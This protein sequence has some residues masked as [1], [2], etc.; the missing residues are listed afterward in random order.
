[1]EDR[2]GIV[3]LKIL[4]SAETKRVWRAR[5]RAGIS[6][7]GWALVCVSVLTCASALLAPPALLRYA[8]LLVLAPSLY[9]LVGKPAWSGLVKRDEERVAASLE[10][11]EVSLTGNVRPAVDLAGHIPRGTSTQLAAVAQELAV[12]RLQDHDSATLIGARIRL[13]WKTAIIGAVTAAFVVTAS[14]GAPTE[15]ARAGMPWLDPEPPLPSLISIAPGDTAVVLGT[16]IPVRCRIKNLG[17]EPASL[18][19]RR[20]GDLDRIVH[21]TSMEVTP[22][23]ATLRAE[24]GTTGSGFRYAILA[25]SDSSAWFTV[26]VFNKPK[27]TDMKI[28]YAY[29]KY[30]GLESMELSGI[31]KEIRAIRGTGATVTLTTNNRLSSCTVAS[32]SSN[33][34]DTLRVN[35]REATLDFPVLERT[36][37]IFSAADDWGQICS[38]GPLDVEPIPDAPPVLE[39]VIPGQDVLL[40]R[41]LELEVGATA[42]DDFGLTTVKIRYVMGELERTLVLAQGALGREG[43]WT[44][45]WSLDGLNLLP[46]DIVAYR[47]EASDNDA[48][49]GPKTSTTDWFHLRF[50]SLAE[51]ISK[52]DQEESGLLDSLEE[53][54]DENRELYKELRE[55]AADLAGAESATWG[56]RQDLRELAEKQRKLGERL[57]SLADEL[58][59]IEQ[60]SEDAELV[61]VELLEKVAKVQDLLRDIDLPELTEAMEEIQEALDELTADE[62]EKALSHLASHQEDVLKSLDKA[63]E[64][65]EKLHTAQKLSHL[66]REAERLAAEQETLM[67]T[68]KKDQSAPENAALGEKQIAQDLTSVD[69]GLEEVAEDISKLS[70]ALAESLEAALDR[71]RSSETEETLE[72]AAESLMKGAWDQAAESQERALDGLQQLSSDLQAAEA[73]MTNDDSRRLMMALDEAQETVGELAREQENISKAD[74]GSEPSRGQEVGIANAL[75]KLR[76]SLEQIFAKGTGPAS[77]ELLDIMAKTQNQLDRAVQGKSG[78]RGSSESR[79]SLEALNRVSG[80]LDQ[81]KEQM[82][83]GGSSSG[84]MDMEQLF[85]LSQSQS[86]LNQMCRSMF[87]NAG[88]LSRKSLSSIAARQQMI[89]DQLSRL[90]ESLRGQGRLMGNLGAAGEEMGEII[91]ELTRAGLNEDVLRRQ[92]K[93]MTR[94]LDAQKSIRRQGLARRRSSISAEKQ[95]RSLPGDQILYDEVETSPQAPPPRRDDPYPSSYREIIDAYFE[96]LAR[97][98]AG[99]GQTT[100]DR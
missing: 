55:A 18:V 61:P 94:M 50:P 40:N 77:S 48:I 67:E 69:E 10:S 99:R 72:Q 79:R 92:R 66:T 6:V 41:D 65:L 23:V 43:S 59:K 11:A 38:L 8:F 28:R 33:S 88:G 51:I 76:E 82:N 91:D 100:D 63:I 86:R 58:A 85:G 54:S 96:A 5:L 49:G 19:I 56:D 89:R 32:R 9:W 83:Q 64:L 53:L 27:F 25:G 37:L 98:S 21:L 36:R 35:G 81:M 47:F 73:C 80:A 44:K 12:A 60:T 1:M 70:T 46:E 95:G 3:L 97:P 84:S 14:G 45:W 15:W 7:V 24:M 87:P 31:T 74:R 78:R 20:P 42:S 68:T 34:I 2:P 30:T 39:T 93:I 52:V 75:R 57:D 4:S 90:S 22:S 13:P 26:K 71:L 29:P 16:R 62:I 17:D